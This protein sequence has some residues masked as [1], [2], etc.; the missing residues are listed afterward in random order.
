MLN[1]TNI[2]MIQP[3]G[4]SKYLEYYSRK[5]AKEKNIDKER[6]RQLEVINNKNVIKQN[7]NF[8]RGN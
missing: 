4:K 8:F 2:F 1:T 6:K 3:F 5:T 7:K